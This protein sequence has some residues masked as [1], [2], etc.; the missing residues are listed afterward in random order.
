MQPMLSTTKK[1]HMS[2]LLWDTEGYI[3]FG[4]Y[5]H[6]IID[7]IIIAI[8]KAPQM[9]LSVH[10]E[11]SEGNI[12]VIEQTTNVRG[13]AVHLKFKQDPQNTSHNHHLCHF[14]V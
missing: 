5:C 13:R 14:A 3:K 2:D 11:R 10:Q 4:N 8:A 9:N 1:F 6:S 7:I 12:Q